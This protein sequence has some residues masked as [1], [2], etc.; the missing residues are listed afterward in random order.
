MTRAAPPT[1]KSIMEWSVGENSD[2]HLPE[3]RIQLTD[4]IE[5]IAW[6]MWLT[7]CTED[8]VDEL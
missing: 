7:A 4:V 5:A 6:A 1:A 8:A 2:T 3:V